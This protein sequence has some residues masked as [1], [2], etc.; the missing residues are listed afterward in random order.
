MSRKPLIFLIALFVCAPL[1]ALA[2]KVEFR[3]E[4]AILPT[5]LRDSI[6]TQARQWPFSTRV[7]TS[8]A[9][10]NRGAFERRA[11]DALNSSDMLVIGIDPAHRYVVIRM[12]TGLNLEPGGYSRIASAG[13]DNFKNSRWADG[14][15]AIGQKAQSQVTYSNYIQHSKSLEVPVR[16]PPRIVVH[17][18]EGNSIGWLLLGLIVTLIAICSVWAI[19]TRRR[20]R[21]ARID[22]EAER[23]LNADRQHANRPSVQT[24]A[25]ASFMP[26]QY[27]AAPREPSYA[28]GPQPIAVP[29]PTPAP[30]STPIVRP[31]VQH[32]YH[33]PAPA[34]AAPVVIHTDRSNDGLI[35]G[36]LLNEAMHSHHHHDHSDRHVVERVVEVEREP[37]S[38]R[39]DAGGS[40]SSWSAPVE[41]SSYS[42]PAPSFDSSSSFDAGGSSSSWDSGSSSS[43][44]D[45]GSSSSFDSGGGSSDF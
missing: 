30:A 45:S 3:D 10:A 20:D 24:N 9:S 23:I 2:G 34:P 7:L 14:I 5:P 41:E 29:A 27:Q 15:I 13:N 32:V 6:V 42:S 35:T 26:S 36:M 31:I 28:P 38:S 21:Q 16:P 12:G 17:E 40:S 11:M 43:S 8:T 1:V 44:F 33:Q 39:Y 37:A 18:T 25:P 4:A 22:A 19:I